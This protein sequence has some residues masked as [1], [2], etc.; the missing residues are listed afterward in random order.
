MS[1]K[2][3]QIVLFTHP[4]EIDKKGEK[5]KDKDGK[6]IPRIVSPAIVQEVNADGSILCHV[7]SNFGGQVS[8]VFAKKK[9]ADLKDDEC[10]WEM[11]A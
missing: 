11:T 9:A 2:V 7:F 6:D 3:G 1:A 4:V 8:R 5:K 10:A